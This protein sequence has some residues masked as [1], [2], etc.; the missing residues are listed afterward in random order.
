MAKD[1]CVMAG[2]ALQE[3]SMTENDSPADDDSAADKLEI[4]SLSEDKNHSSVEIGVTG[5]PVCDNCFQINVLRILT[6]AL[7]CLQQIFATVMR[8]H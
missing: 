7:E 6:V 4:D 3:D 5:M 1:N 8:I 2:L